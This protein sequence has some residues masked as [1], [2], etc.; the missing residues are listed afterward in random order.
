MA[1]K[2]PKA[3]EIF[4]QTM[5]MFGSKVPFEVAFPHIEDIFVEVQESLHATPVIRTLNL[6][7]RTISEFINCRDS[8]CYNGGFSIGNV[9]REMVRSGKTEHQT[10]LTTCQGGG[11][12]QR[13]RKKIHGSCYHFFKAKVTIKY[14]EGSGTSQRYGSATGL[15]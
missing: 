8:R 14:K 15:V 9:V 10:D 5:P 2:R 7:K 4:D 3:Q 6:D 13:G 11:G 12:P 1:N